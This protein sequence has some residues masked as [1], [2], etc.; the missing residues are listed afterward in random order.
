MKRLLVLSTGETLLSY[1][2]LRVPY[3]VLADHGYQVT[4]RTVEQVYTPDLLTAFTQDALVLPVSVPLSETGLA[5]CVEVAH[6]VPLI[7]DLTEETALAD[8]A[9]R[10]QLRAA[11]LVSVPTEVLARSVRGVTRAV[12]VLPS[13]LSLPPPLSPATL[14]TH[15]PVVA[16]YGSYDWRLL[17][18]LAALPDTITLIG[19]R[20][21]GSI[22]GERLSVIEPTVPGWHALLRSIW[23]GLCPIESVNTPVDPIWSLEYALAGARLLT[24]SAGA[25]ALPFVRTDLLLAHSRAD[26]LA[27]V[28]QVCTPPFVNAP[29]LIATAFW[30]RASNQS[31]PYLLALSQILA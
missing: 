2:R 27:Q 25:R 17:G 7:C 5:Q 30:H 12:R 1:R 18:D 29:G 19:D 28:T 21:A 24:S 31:R 3:Q 13:G 8:P 6:R 10:A 26:W 11:R 16:C 23:L 20:R 9:I 15:R 4:F 22:L 14:R